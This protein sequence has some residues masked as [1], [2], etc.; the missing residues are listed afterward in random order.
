MK[1]FPAVWTTGNEEL[2]AI[3]KVF[4]TAEALAR[5][6]PRTASST[7]ASGPTPTARAASSAPRSATITR[8][9]SDPILP[10][11]A[12]PRPA[13]VGR[14]ASTT[15]ASP[16]RATPPR[17]SESVRSRR[18]FREIMEE[19]EIVCVARRLAFIIGTGGTKYTGPNPTRPDHDERMRGAIMNRTIPTAL[20]CLAVLG[21][22]ATARAQPTAGEAGVHDR[23]GMFSAEAVKEA[24]EALRDVRRQT[25]WS[26][27][28]ETVDSLDGKTIKDAALEN[29]KRPPGP[30]PLRPDRQERAQVLRRAEPTR[31]Q[32]AFTHETI[33]AI[34]DAILRALQG[35]EVRPGASRRRRPD[36][37]RRRGRPRLRQRHRRPPPPAPRRR[38]PPTPPPR[39]PHRPHRPGRPTPARPAVPTAPGRRPASPRRGRSC[40]C[41]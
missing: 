25:H 26:A 23:A 37:P 21:A 20:A 9:M 31:P 35:R 38:S 22:G 18:E 3:N 14:P 17:R 16:S 30:R 41:S 29:A 11:P 24:D 36:P 6:R 33:K 39:R 4:P 12:H 5:L 10:R 2:Y 1:G 19:S 40:R 27:V 8:P 15:T 32:K 28:I 13:L 7:P 34:D